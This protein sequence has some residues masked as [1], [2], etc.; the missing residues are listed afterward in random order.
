MDGKLHKVKSVYCLSKVLT[1]CSIQKVSLHFHFTEN[2]F[3]QSTTFND[4]LHDCIFPAKLYTIML[5][6]PFPALQ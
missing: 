3:V 2:T 1:L 5:E 4:M 6:N